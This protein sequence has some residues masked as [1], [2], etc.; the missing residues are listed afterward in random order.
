MCHRMLFGTTGTMANLPLT[1]NAAAAAH[2]QHH[3]MVS[4]D[5]SYN[6]LDCRI[7]L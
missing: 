2:A 1:S 7:F 6:P 5:H 4:T 3:S